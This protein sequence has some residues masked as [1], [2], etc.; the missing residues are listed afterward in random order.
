MLL[1]D[2]LDTVD[3]LLI[4]LRVINR[5]EIP[6]DLKRNMRTLIVQEINKIL[7]LPCPLQENNITQPS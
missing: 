4:V 2:K 7:I 6:P 1:E 3:H 5:Q